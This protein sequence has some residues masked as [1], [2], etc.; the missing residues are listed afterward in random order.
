MKE[1]DNILSYFVTLVL[2]NDGFSAT[3]CSP[4]PL[5]CYLFMKKQKIS[6]RNTIFLWYSTNFLTLIMYLSQNVLLLVHFI[7]FVM[8]IMSSIGD[9][10]TYYNLFKC[11]FNQKYSRNT[12]KF[13]KISIFITF[14]TTGSTKSKC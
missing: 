6:L 7:F 8:A 2:K 1:K 13:N 5:E 14:C 11:N 10:Q 12:Y 3:G 9:S 4:V